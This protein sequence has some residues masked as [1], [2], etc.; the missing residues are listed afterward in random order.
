MNKKL[1]KIIIATGGTGGHVFPAYSL[2]KHFINSKIDVELTTDKRGLQYL[3][4]FNDIKITQ[5]ATSTIY[6]KNIFK[7]ISSSFIIFYSILHSLIYLLS[8]KPNFVFGMGGYSS[9]PLCIAAKMLR[10]PLI[11]YENNLHIG[12]ANKYLL[13]FA[14]KIFVSWNDLKGI[15][16]KYLK[17]NL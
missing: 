15:K 4:D 6:K 1:K 9:F 12:K 7:L 17:K 16:N 8:K 11:I 5:I 3:K 14:T 2:A 10:I 13:P